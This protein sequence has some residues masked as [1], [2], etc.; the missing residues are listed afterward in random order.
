M[1]MIL[2]LGQLRAI[3]RFFLLRKKKVELGQLRALFKNLCAA[4]STIQEFKGLFKNLYAAGSQFRNF[5]ASTKTGS[6]FFFFGILKGFG[7][8]SLVAQ[9][10]SEE[11]SFFL[12]FVQVGLVG[13]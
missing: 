13:E 12:F 5:I 11:S 2:P 10:E 3:F 6:S 7:G 8:D 4:G 9:R 1:I